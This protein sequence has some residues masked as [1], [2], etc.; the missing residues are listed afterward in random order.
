[1]EAAGRSLNSSV[2]NPLLGSPHLKRHVQ[3]ELDNIVWGHLC[4]IKRLMESQDILYEL[5]DIREFLSNVLESLETF[6]EKIEIMVEIQ[7][8]DIDSYRRILEEV[9]KIHGN[10][11]DH[12]LLP[13]FASLVAAL[14]SAFSRLISGIDRKDDPRKGDLVDHC[15]NVLY[16]LKVNA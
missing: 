4:I 15:E 1:M 10:K 11:D 9:A 7:I 13:R 16:Q 12:D 14:E 2:S 5:K 8:Q 6:F 3:W